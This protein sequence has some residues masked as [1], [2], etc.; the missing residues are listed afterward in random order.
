[1]VSKRNQIGGHE[2]LVNS[3]N[4]SSIE[5]LLEDFQI[6]NQLLQEECYLV[7]KQL[8]ATG[9]FLSSS[10]ID[11]YGTVFEDNSFVDVKSAFD[12]LMDNI[13]REEEF[14]IN[15]V[16]VEVEENSRGKNSN[17]SKQYNDNDVEVN[18]VILGGG[19]DFGIDLS[20]IT[21]ETVH[22]YSTEV[23]LWLINR[24]KENYQDLSLQQQHSLSLCLVEYQ[25]KAMVSLNKLYLG[26]VGISCMLFNAF[27]NM[28]HVIQ[29]NELEGGSISEWMSSVST[30]TRDSVDMMNRKIRDL[31]IETGK[32]GKTI[33]KAAHS[34]I[35]K[36]PLDQK[37]NIVQ[38]LFKDML[39]WC[40]KQLMIRLR[41]PEFDVASVSDMSSFKEEIIKFINNRINQILRKSEAYRE[42]ENLRK[43]RLIWVLSILENIDSLLELIKTI[44]QMSV[45]SLNAD[46]GLKMKV[47]SSMSKGIEVN[48]EPSQWLKDIGGSVEGLKSIIEGK[49]DA[50]IHSFDITI[51]EI[52]REGESNRK[53][54]EIDRQLYL[55]NLSIA[56][57]KQILEKHPNNNIVSAELGRLE[58][59]RDKL[60]ESKMKQSIEIEQTCIQLLQEIKTYLTAI[61]IPNVPFDIISKKVLQAIAK[62][63]DYT[64]FTTV[65]NNIKNT[66]TEEISK[67]NIGLN[68]YFSCIGKY[69]EYCPNI[70]N[71]FDLIG[72]MPLDFSNVIDKLGTICGFVGDIASNSSM[73]L[74]AINIC[75]FVI[76][77]IVGATMNS[78]NK[79]LNKEKLTLQDIKKAS[80]DRIAKSGIKGGKRKK[81]IYG[82]VLP[83]IKQS[84]GFLPSISTQKQL[85]SRNN[86][87]R[88]SQSILPP[89]PNYTQ[90]MSSQNTFPP[91]KQPHSSLPPIMQSQGKTYRMRQGLVDPTHSYPFFVKGNK[92]ILNERI[93]NH[94]V[95]LLKPENTRKHILDNV[96]TKSINSSS[97]LAENLIKNVDDYIYANELS[98]DNKR[99]VLDNL[100]GIIPHLNVEDYNINNC[101][102]LPT[103]L[104]NEEDLYI[105]SIFARYQGEEF[106][107]SFDFKNSYVRPNSNT[108]YCS[109]TKKIQ[110]D[111]ERL[112]TVILS[113]VDNF[114][115]NYNELDGGRMKRLRKKDKEEI[116]QYLEKKP[117]KQLYLYASSKNIPTDCKM[118]KKDLIQ[119]II[120]LKTL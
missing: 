69:I 23:L 81:I 32:A 103:Q 4:T 36:M 64:A 49:K 89:V 61:E 79:T 50:L 66:A 111:D 75:L 76:H 78:R 22:L 12:T 119:T 11:A 46:I 52:I 71:I 21:E 118:S 59:L 56:K 31:A 18:N 47:K 13:E 43:E 5:D 83:E 6:Y 10:S 67:L 93:R 33:A 26:D 9:E 3:L 53:A 96:L 87:I 17:I 7:F 108:L 120:N 114:I 15:T 110:L 60:E 62:K 8:Q 100:K 112:K 51:L 54:K 80:Q 40:G 68:T 44:S 105:L 74:Q 88:E 72:F 16:F 42:K 58:K 97:L 41:A 1:M 27:T 19:K 109:A 14:V 39:K 34:S 90:T 106:R 115:G 98:L 86:V 113:I 94:I 35:E 91:L 82:G 65:A 2:Q 102:T 92:A 29:K 63:V 38:N 101:N 70:E 48:I 73:Y 57:N 30:L 85:T 55:L 25:L 20:S 95:Y 84:Q 99:S 77:L 24:Y 28:G 117:T 107:R 37:L 45:Q 104:Q 116:K